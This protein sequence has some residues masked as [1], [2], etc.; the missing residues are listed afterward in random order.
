MSAMKQKDIIN[1]IDVADVTDSVLREAMALRLTIIG[2]IPADVGG[3]R[4][5]VEAVEERA[6]SLIDNIRDLRSMITTMLE[7]QGAPSIVRAFAVPKRQEDTP[8]A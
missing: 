1:L 7:R 3:Q 2:L 8:C 6:I 5:Y 4:K